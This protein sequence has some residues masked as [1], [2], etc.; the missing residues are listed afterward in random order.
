LKARFVRKIGKLRLRLAS[1]YF[2]AP[3]EVY[4]AKSDFLAVLRST[5]GKASADK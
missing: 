2:R 4:E 3:Y 1:H 5:C